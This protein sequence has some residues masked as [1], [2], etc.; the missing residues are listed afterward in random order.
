VGAG[1]AASAQG[2]GS[3][4]PSTPRNAG[5]AAGAACGSS[6]SQLGNTVVVA[7]ALRNSWVGFRLVPVTEVRL[8][9]A[10]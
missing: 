8:L 7:A 1:K 6:G 10:L 5:L 2:Q 3:A 9:F 4:A